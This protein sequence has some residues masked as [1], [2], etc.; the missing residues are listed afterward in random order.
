M[1]LCYTFSDGRT[2][3]RL[4]YVYGG[5]EMLEAF[6]A[7]EQSDEFQSRT[8]PLYY[9]TA[10]E[11]PSRELALC[12]PTGLNILTLGTDD[13]D[14]AALVAALR[15]DLLAEPAADYYRPG[16]RTVCYRPGKAN[17]SS[18]TAPSRRKRTSTAALRCRWERAMPTRW[19]CWSN[20][21]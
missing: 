10:E 16:R 12:D 13:Y 8:N 15:Q 18:G 7:L 11:N 19:R 2:M 9:W 3:K 1:E 4:Y 6:S 5:E 21:A 17:G 20:G 14:T